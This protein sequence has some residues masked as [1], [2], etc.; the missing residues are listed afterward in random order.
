MIRFRYAACQLEILAECGSVEEVRKD[1]QRLPSTLDETYERILRNIN[2]KHREDAIQALAMILGSLENTGPILAQT[3]VSAVVNR[4]PKAGTKGFCTIDTLRRHCICL[5]KVRA[6]K[7]VD[8]AHYTVREFLQSARLQ[9]KLPAFALPEKRVDEIFCNTVMVTATRFS[10]TPNLLGMPEDQNGDPVDF[11]LYALRRTRMAM[12]W[13]RQTLVGT[14]GNPQNKGLLMKL[15][16]PYEP[17]FRGLQLLGSD[18]HSDEGNELQFEWLPKFNPNADAMEKAAAH[19]T[20]LVSFEMPSLVKD[21][22]K[23][24]SHQQ[25]AALFSTP[26]NVIFPANWSLYSQHGGYDPKPTAVTVLGFYN[27]GLK[28]GY[29]TKAEIKMLQSEFGSFTTASSASTTGAGHGHTAPASRTNKTPASSSRDTGSSGRHTPQPTGNKGGANSTPAA[30]SNKVPPT[31][32][33]A[34]NQHQSQP[35]TGHG[36]VPKPH[37]PAPPHGHNSSSSGNTSGKPAAA[38]D[39]NGPNR[40]AQASRG[41]QNGGAPSSS[42]ANR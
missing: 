27:E 11:R 4:G 1:I 32:G 26:M 28:R 30:P 13:S 41:A 24:K 36:Q 7:T 2:P 42:H 20:M 14:A 12:F 22:L 9:Q 16:N 5:I 25:K 19:L 39:N 10:G 21:Y 23:S 18:G 34:P 29:D 38:A 37:A 33:P 15:L 40:N 8:L 31:R 6:N 3:L 17:P 35:Q